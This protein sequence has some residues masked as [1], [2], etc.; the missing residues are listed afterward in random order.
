MWDGL[1]LFKK[2]LKGFV[3]LILADSNYNLRRTLRKKCPYSE[4]LWSV[5]SHI[6]TEYGA[7][8]SISQTTWRL[9][10]CLMISLRENCLYLEFFW[11]VFSRIWTEYGISLRIQS[12]CGKIRTRKSSNT[13]TFHAVESL[14]M[15]IIFMWSFRCYPSISMSIQR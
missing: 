14:N 4:F 15:Y 12:K 11:S 10:A 8:G 5:F 3:P 2:H 6:R 9:C 7:I 13:D 1:K